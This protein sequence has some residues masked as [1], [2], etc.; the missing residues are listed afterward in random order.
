VVARDVYSESWYPQSVSQKYVKPGNPSH[1]V[2]EMVE[3]MIESWGLHK[4]FPDRIRDGPQI[5]RRH[6][7]S[8]RMERFSLLLY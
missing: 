2:E 8:T 3:A 6:S 4:M 5:S 7:V 1:Y